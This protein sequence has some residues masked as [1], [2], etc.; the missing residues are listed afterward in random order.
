MEC[1]HWFISLSPPNPTYYAIYAHPVYL[2]WYYS[3]FGKEH[4][5]TIMNSKRISQETFIHYHSK[6]LKS[7]CN[8][9]HLNDMF[10][11]ST[12]TIKF[13]VVKVLINVR[14]RDLSVV[15]ERFSTNFIN[16]FILSVL[17]RAN[18]I[19]L[20]MVIRINIKLPRLYNGFS[21]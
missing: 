11:H 8:I 2:S 17:R 7:C 19:L 15:W 4:T 9:C 10:V 13:M 3:S 14:T 5:Y 1:F 12:R 21:L 16:S 20:A 18:L 6:R